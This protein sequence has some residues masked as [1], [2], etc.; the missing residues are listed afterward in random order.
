MARMISLCA[1]A[2]IVNESWGSSRSEARRCAG[3][4]ESLDALQVRVGELAVRLER[5]EDASIEE[6]ER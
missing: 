4:G 2:L 1:A 3:V 5:L 6:R